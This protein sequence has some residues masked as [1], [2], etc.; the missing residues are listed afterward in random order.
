MKKFCIALFACCALVSCG[1]SNEAA[2]TTS[3]VV[4]ADTLDPE[5]VFEYTIT[6]GEN[7]GTDVVIEVPQGKLVSLSVVNPSSHDDVH[8]HGYD[9]S[10]GSIE[11]GETG[12]MMFEAS[13]TGDFEIESHET[14][15]LIS[16]LRVTVP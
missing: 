4:T 6:V 10:T 9:L 12:S 8:L 5:N 1:G 16:I 11:K 14:G 15:E 13:K 7:T 3:L 2:S